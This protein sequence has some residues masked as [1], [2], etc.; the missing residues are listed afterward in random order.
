MISEE[1][2]LDFVKFEGEKFLVGLV[3]ALRLRGLDVPNCFKVHPISIS[4]AFLR[5]IP[6]EF[7]YA[8]FFEV[9]NSD[10]TRLV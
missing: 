5:S 3:L 10:T 4:T 9:D 6:S 1:A 8:S 2:A 7:F